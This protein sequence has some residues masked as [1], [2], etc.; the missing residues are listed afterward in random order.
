MNLEGTGQ[1]QN[2]DQGRLF[3]GHVDVILNPN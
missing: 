2:E 3:V 1:P